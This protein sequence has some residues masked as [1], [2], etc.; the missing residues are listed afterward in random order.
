M[1]HFTMSGKVSVYFNRP[2]QADATTGINMNVI[3]KKINSSRG[4]TLIELMI[5][6]SI[7]G[8]LLTIAQPMYRDS[9]IKA[10]EA[11]LMENLFSLRDVIDQYYVDKGQY[12][13]SLE[14]LTGSGYIRSIPKDPFT[15]ST[16]T[17]QTIPP[18]E[19][20]EGSLYDIHSGS[21]KIALDGTAYNEW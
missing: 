12:P 19:G 18:P 7:I 2:E 16:E 11:V 20:Y 4:F 21:D 10:K 6:M 17:W 14:D 1:G 13:D 5:V 3:R 15:K 9:T 8:I